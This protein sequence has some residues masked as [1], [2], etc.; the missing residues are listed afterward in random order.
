M[1]VSREALLAAAN[2]VD[3]YEAIFRSL[4][5]SG[6][7]ENGV[8]T[9]H[10]EAPPYHSNAVILSPMDGDTQRNIIRRLSAELARPFSFKDGFATHDFTADGFRTLFEAEWIWRAPDGHRRSRHDDGG[11]D[12]RR[13]TTPAELEAWEGGLR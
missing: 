6:A 4:G 11:I 7:I 9:S 10:D 8:W 5:L 13:V 3:W 1:A 12:W 2:N